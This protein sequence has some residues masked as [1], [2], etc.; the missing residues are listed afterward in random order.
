[1]LY[2][3][4]RILD[5]QLPEFRDDWAQML[6]SV[7]LD[8]DDDST[9]LTM[10]V[11]IGNIA[12]AGVVE[13]HRNDGM[14]AQGNEIN[15]ALTE[16]T[17]QGRRYWDYTGYE[18]VN[19]AYRLT[20]AGRWQPAIVDT[21][22]GIFRV[23]QFVTPQWAIST[24]FSITNPLQF[25]A[26]P[27]TASDPTNAA[28]YRAQA[29]A[30]LRA[31]AAMTDEQKMMAELFNDKVASLASAAGF[32]IESR[33]LT[34]EDFVFF[35]LTLSIAAYDAGIAIWAQKRRHDAVRPLSAI[36]HLYGNA[37][38]TAWGGV[39]RGTQSIPATQ[40]R[41]YLPVADH[42]EYPSA[43][44]A[45]CAA[46]A[47]AAQLYLN[48]DTL[49]WFIPYAEGS[50]VIEPGITPQRNITI[51]WD[52]FTEFSADCGDS[53]FWSGVHFEPSIPA[54]Q[55]IGQQVARHAYDFMSRHINGTP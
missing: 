29:D 16:R 9:D 13:K 46:Y 53:R 27:P 33:G 24:P 3:T 32:V 25:S 18:P 51:G 1:M 41:S 50:S 7:G 12:G 22:S 55:S 10:P 45:F 20:D 17:D 48:S 21:G 2:A 43:S 39:G 34:M 15:P 19:T 35:D 42:P 30:V 47:E 26:P 14:N 6:R 44:A 11:G 49:N 52:T 4:R 40:W 54:G 38:V 31:S 36:R 8:P 5:V 37:P 23:Q 28:E